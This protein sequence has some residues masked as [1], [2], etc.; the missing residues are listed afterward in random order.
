MERITDKIKATKTKDYFSDITQ[1]EKPKE[2]ISAEEYEKGIN[3]I[4][5]NL[6]TVIE[7]AHEEIARH[8]MGDIPDAISFS[9]IAKTY[10]GKSRAWLMQKVNGNTVNGKAASFTDAERKQFRNALL[11]ISNKLSA[12]AQNF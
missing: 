6:D 5:E 12:A 1:G 2:N 11:D 9:Y 7:D 10:F 8:L 3:E 4:M